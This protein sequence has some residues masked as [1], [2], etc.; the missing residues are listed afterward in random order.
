MDK[1]NIKL[2]VKIF[3]VP[4]QFRF[5]FLNIVRKNKLISF[6]DS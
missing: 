5:R 2:M 6:N 1:M 4:Q 3:I